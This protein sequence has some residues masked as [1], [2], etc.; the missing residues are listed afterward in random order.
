VHASTDDFLAAMRR[1]ATGVAIVTTE[2]KGRIHGFTAN[3]FAS[4]SAAPPTVLI[5]VN[6]GATAHPLIAQSQRFCVNIL[7]LDQRELAVR[8]AGG[9]PRSRFDGVEYRIGS[10][11]SPILEGTLAYLDCTLAE[12]LTAATHTIFLG[13]VL[14]AGWRDGEPLGY[15]NRAYRDFALRPPL[16]DEVSRLGEDS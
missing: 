16:P 14:D 9:E 7:S 11:G 13:I 8:F 10:S 3:A 6:R 15:F 1:F 2:H 12:E 4:V 5:C